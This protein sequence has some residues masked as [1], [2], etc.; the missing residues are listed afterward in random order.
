MKERKKHVVINAEKKRCTI[1]KNANHAMDSCLWV[2]AFVNMYKQDCVDAK[3]MS[4]SV[5]KE[6]ISFENGFLDG[7]WIGVRF[8]VSNRKVKSPSAKL[9]ITRS[10]IKREIE[11]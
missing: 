8:F 7:G 2:C 3:R 6:I 9:N 11:A 4:A 10:E 5:Q 1:L